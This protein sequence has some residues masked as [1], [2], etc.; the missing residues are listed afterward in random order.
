MVEDLGNQDQMTFLA[1]YL[2]RAGA[3][4]APLRPVGYQ[5]LE[6]VLD[7]DDAGVTFSGAWTNSTSSI[8]FGSAG[9]VPYRFATTSATE[10][11]VARYRPEI[12]EAGFYP[13]YAW[14]HYGSDRA[15]DQL[16]RINHSGGST[17]VTVNHRRVGDGGVRVGHEGAG[18]VSDAVHGFPCTTPA[19]LQT[20]GGSVSRSYQRCMA[21][22]ATN[23]DTPESPSFPATIPPS[24]LPSGRVAG[25]RQASM[26]RLSVPRKSIGLQC[27]Y[28]SFRNSRT[29]P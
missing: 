7:N 29:W 11:A 16:Y 26:V 14:S 1:D 18:G 28:W 5:P 17:E 15:A 10:T 3:T 2:F 4:I 22:A 19:A 6:V 9:D 25:R 27:R 23:A 21:S 20:R 8:Y 24:A 13:V 12:A